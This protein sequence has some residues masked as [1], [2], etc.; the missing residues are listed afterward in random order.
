MNA[1]NLCIFSSD[2]VFGNHRGRITIETRT[3]EVDE[4]FAAEHFPMKPGR[5]VRLE[6]SDSGI[7]MDKQTLAQIFEP[8]FTTKGP[9]KG[10][11][12]GLATVYGIVKQSGGYVWTR[13][14]PGQGSTFSVYLP[15][16]IAEVEP[17]MQE[18]KPLETTRG[19]ETILVVEDAAPLRALIR[20]LLECFAYTVL[21]AED[22]ER[23]HQIADHQDIDLLLTDLSLPKTSG[24]TLAQSLR[25]QRPGL[26]VL[27]MSGYPNEAVQLGVQEGDTDFIQKPFT[28]EALAQKLRNLLDA[29]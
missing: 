6:V 27:Y 3:M 29:A 18:T 15:V 16:V 28:Q 12:L 1:R 14:E 13:S 26:K 11:G 19:S 22:A 5:Y 7:G 17:P 20:E 21:D 8:F 10:T 24:L 2:G 23:A 25:K 4:S 9:E